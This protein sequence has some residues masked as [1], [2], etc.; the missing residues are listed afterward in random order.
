MFLAVALPMIELLGSS[1]TWSELPDAFAA[2]HEAVRNSFAFAGVAA[3][4]CLLFGMVFW[5]WRAGAAMWLLFLLPGVLLGIA[6]IFLL[7]RA[8]LAAFYQS[9]GVVVLALGLGMPRSSWAG[10][11]HAMRALDIRLMD[12]AR[13]NGATRWQTFRHV[14][15]PQIA[16]DLGALWFVTYLLCLWDVETIVLIIPPGCETLSL[17]IFNLLH[18]GHNA[19]VSALCALLLGLAVLPL[20]AV[21][22]CGSPSSPAPAFCCSGYCSP[23]GA[24]CE[25]GSPKDAVVQSKLF[26]SVKIIG[27]RGTAL[28]QFN[29]PRSLALDAHD[30]LF[31]VDM[32]G[33][34]QKFSSNGVYL[35][36]LANAP[37]RQG[38]TQGHVPRHGGKHRGG[39]AALQ[40]RQ[41]LLAGWQA[42]GRNGDARAPIRESSA[43]LGPWRSMGRATSWS[44]NTRRSIV[45]SGSLPDGKRATLAFG[46]SG[47]GPGEFNRPEGL[48]VDDQ[49]RIYVADS[50]NHRIQV[51][52]PD[53]QLS[54]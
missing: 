25:E 40:S 36:V 14:Y 54:A 31:V 7:N 34:V 10:A 21:G 53:G 51:F 35:F 6:L 11:R 23:F 4:G 12:F 49:N 44:A 13:L 50:C 47:R 18:Y 20:I 22:Y 19:Q 41:P 32:T 38:Q 24:G 33:R 52:S 46:R 45:S 43:C 26:G 17:R 16:P 39:R 8:P 37:N 30:N 27:A 48:A 15:W 9:A 2:G 1:R 29:K 28:G 42:D 5:R 3:S